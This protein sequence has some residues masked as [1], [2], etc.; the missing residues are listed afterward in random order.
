MY[1][2]VYVGMRVCM[3]VCVY[4]WMS[5]YVCMYVRMCVHMYVRMHVCMWENVNVYVEL[6]VFTSSCEWYLPEKLCGLWLGTCPAMNGQIHVMNGQL[7][8]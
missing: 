6:C 8:L 2:F 5:M 7:L 3:H 1:V 4:V